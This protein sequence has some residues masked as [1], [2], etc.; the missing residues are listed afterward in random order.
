MARKK[1]EQ[2]ETVHVLQRYNWVRCR[3]DAAVEGLLFRLPGVVRLQTFDR[4]EEAQAEFAR[5]EEAARRA[6]NPFLCGGG[7][8]HF[9][10]SYPGQVLYDWLLDADIK[11]PKPTEAGWDW[12][13]WWPQVAPTLTE[14]QWRHV[15]QAFDRLNFY[16]VIGKPRRPLVYVLGQI[17]WRYND[18]GFDPAPEGSKPL[19]AFRTRTRAEA[20]CADEND[21]ARSALDVGADGVDLND[22]EYDMTDRAYRASPFEEPGKEAVRFYEV[23][24]VELADLEG[25]P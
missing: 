20:E 2:S 7:A 8:L 22:E 21:I 10:T 16:Q 1:V 19:R 6:V 11:P 17:G 23:V 18:Q 13:A 12:A 24:E 15:W 9:Q 3:D 4:A 14:A 25:T 5:L